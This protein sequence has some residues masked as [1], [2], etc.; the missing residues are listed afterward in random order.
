MAEAAEFLVPKKQRNTNTQGK[1][2]S[3]RL[4]F[5]ANLV[6]NPLDQLMASLNVSIF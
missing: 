6:G 2:K 1:I 5:L 4:Y 3:N